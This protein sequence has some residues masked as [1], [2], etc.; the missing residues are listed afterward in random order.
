MNLNLNPQSHNYVEN[1]LALRK[2]KELHTVVENRLIQ[3]LALSIPKLY[4]VKE[5]QG[6]AG[7]RN[8]LMLF[9]FNGKTVVFEIFATASQVSRD[10]LILHKTKADIKIA[11]IIDKEANSKIF[12]RFLR[13]NPDTPFPFLFIAELFDEPLT[14]T[15]LKLR[16]LINGDDEAKFQ[17][18]LKEKIS[19]TNFLNWCKQHGIEVFSESGIADG[20]VT[21]SQIFITVVLAKLIQKGVSRDRLKKLGIWLSKNAFKYIFMKVNIGFN[22][23]LYTDLDESFCA[24]SDLKLVDLIRAGHYLSDP[25][26]LLPLNRVIYEIEDKYFNEPLLNPE[27]KIYMTIGASQWNETA[28]GRMAVYSL[29]S[30]VESILL[31]PPTI[32]DRSAE[33]YLKLV[34]ISNIDS[35]QSP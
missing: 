15:Y 30:K 32:P 24:Y 9:Q 25:F 7:G 8:D 12:N 11:V 1:L 26:I 27:R 3:L 16:E 29:P 35:T 5:V 33:E 10:L 14:N 18:M 13:E 34:K 2:A 31:L 4:P 20:N 22:M 17:R 21:Y 6:L 28:T 19:P 23:F